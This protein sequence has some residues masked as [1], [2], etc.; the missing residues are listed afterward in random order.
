MLKNL[1]KPNDWAPVWSKTHIHKVPARTIS[2]FGGDM[3]P[4]TMPGYDDI[5]LYEIVYSKSRNE[6]KLVCEGAYYK[7]W[8]EYTEAVQEL[9]RLKND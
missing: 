6:Y 7:C 4:I 8:P 1:F 5:C 3:T 9:N 2:G